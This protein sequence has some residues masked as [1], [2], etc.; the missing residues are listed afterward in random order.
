MPNS[1]IGLRAGREQSVLK[2]H[3]WIFSGG[4]Q[5]AKAEKGDIVDIYS[6]SQQWLAR[7]YYY[8]GGTIACRVLTKKESD[9]IDVDWFI[10]RLRIAYQKRERFLVATNAYRLIFGEADGLPGLIVDIY[11]RVAVVQ[12][13]TFGMERLRPMLFAALPQALAI[14]A[15]YERS[16]IDVRAAESLPLRSGLVWGK[17][18][19]E[20]LIKEGNATFVVDVV[21]GQKTGFFLD[22]RANRQTIA[23]YVK[24]KKVLNTFCYTGAFSVHA[25]LAGASEV[26]S[27]DSSQSAITMTEA[28]MVRN[29]PQVASKAICADAYEFLKTTDQLFDVI[30]LDPPGLVKNKKDLQAG[31]NAYR[32]L[33]QLAMK[34]L[35]PGGIL[36]TASCSG[37]VDRTLFRKIVFWACEYEGRALQQIEE[38]GHTWDHPLSV[39][40]PEGEYLKFAVYQC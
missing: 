32:V 8:P 13:S 2:S 3:P 28:H 23:N 25:G 6:A 22:Q 36:V 37:W 4:I 7:G 9:I 21:K 26:T 39:F 15:I 16:D 10:G 30:I 31:T 17:L 1:Q 5:S 14:D 20:I 40:F 29:C 11:D 33:H 38:R 19:D 18:P 24:G 34:R 35:V 27:V 12:V